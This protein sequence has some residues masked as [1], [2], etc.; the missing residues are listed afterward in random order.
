MTTT[1]NDFLKFLQHIQI[2]HF[3]V[4][5]KKLP[6]IFQYDFIWRKNM[7]NENFFIMKEL[8]YML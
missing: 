7:N 4:L 5:M 2:K 6:N 1:S 3:K 8:W